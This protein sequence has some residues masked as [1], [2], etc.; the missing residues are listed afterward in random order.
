MKNNHLFFI[1]KERQE[2]KKIRISTVSISKTD[3][4]KRS[5]L[6]R[7]YNKRK[8]LMQR[9]ILLGR[10]TL[11][12]ECLFLCNVTADYFISDDYLKIYWTMFVKMH[13]QC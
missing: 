12:T 1:I 8:S 5:D 6:Q 7:N 2:I 13:K 11:E 3:K 4:R 9:N 10:V